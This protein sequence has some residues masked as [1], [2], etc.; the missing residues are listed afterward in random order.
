MISTTWNWPLTSIV[1]TSTLTKRIPSSCNSLTIQS[2][3]DGWKKFCGG[4]LQYLHVPSS[5]DRFDVFWISQIPT[6]WPL[7]QT[8]HWESLRTHIDQAY[9]KNSVSVRGA[10]VSNHILSIQW[11]RIVCF[12]RCLYV[13]LL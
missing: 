8:N 9:S 3:H 4:S 7:L 1:I 10:G 13:F 6:G 2:H 5:D 11:N 12:G